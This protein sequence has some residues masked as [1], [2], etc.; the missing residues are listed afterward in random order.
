[1]Y[2]FEAAFTTLAD[3]VAFTNTLGVGQINKIS[4]TQV[5]NN[6]FKGQEI[7]EVIEEKK[8]VAKK[9]VEKKVVEKKVEVKEEIAPVEI[10]APFD[11]TSALEIAVR[12]VAVLKATGIADNDIMPAIHEVYAQAGC[13]IALKISQFDDVSLSKFIPLFEQKVN[14]I[15]TKAKAA[16]ESSASFI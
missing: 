6:P 3:L 13:D 11:R 9:P 5:E 4:E 1:M 14:A 8:P 15:A 2:K 10:A 12:L 7:P 16:P